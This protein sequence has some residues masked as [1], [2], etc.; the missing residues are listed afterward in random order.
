MFS[1]NITGDG[2]KLFNQYYEKTKSN[3]Q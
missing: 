2:I 3:S 1:K